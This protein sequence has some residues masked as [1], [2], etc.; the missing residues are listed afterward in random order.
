MLES[1]HH[2]CIYVF[3]AYLKTIKLTLSGLNEFVLEKNIFKAW[4]RYLSLGTSYKVD[5]KE[6]CSWGIY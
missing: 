3:E 2:I 5:I 6:I 1:M 4:A